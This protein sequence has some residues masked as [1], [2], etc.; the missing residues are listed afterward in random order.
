MPDLPLKENLIFHGTHVAWTFGSHSYAYS[1]EFNAKLKCF[2]VLESDTK[3]HTCSL[4]C[5]TSKPA[6]FHSMEGPLLVCDY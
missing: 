2:L 5:S 1:G 3:S 6:A 4:V